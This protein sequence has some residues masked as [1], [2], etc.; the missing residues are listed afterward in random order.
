M[1]L[2]T[3]SLT[4][5]LFFIIATLAIPSFGFA[6]AKNKPAGPQDSIDVLANIPSTG[7]SVTRVTETQHYSRTYLYLEHSAGG[8]TLVDITD[9]RHPSVL[10]NLDVPG[11]SVLAAAGDAALVSSDAAPVASARP[12]TMTIM[13]FADPAHPQ[14]VRQ[15]TNV[16]CTAADNGRGLIFVANS[17]GLW[18]LHR[19]PAEDPQVQENYAHEVLYNH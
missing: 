17:E 2:R 7:G 11:A 1:V 12:R 6:K 15:F 8:L 16:T 4:T 14:T 18:I 5:G 19:N 3:A 9:A 10:G 13:N